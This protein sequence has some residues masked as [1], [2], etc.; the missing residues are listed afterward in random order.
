MK[1]HV[2]GIAMFFGVGKAVSRLII[3]SNCGF[4]ELNKKMQNESIGKYFKIIKE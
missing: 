4:V 2:L 1:N 3:Q